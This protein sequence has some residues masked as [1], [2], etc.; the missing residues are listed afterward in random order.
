MFATHLGINRTY[1]SNL[2]L[3]LNNEQLVH[4]EQLTR[5]LRDMMHYTC[6]KRMTK[7]D[8]FYW[9]ADLKFGEL[10]CSNEMQECRKYFF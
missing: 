8:T 4:W 2:Q 3:D 1:M 6:I 9:P 5:L 7:Y 10:L